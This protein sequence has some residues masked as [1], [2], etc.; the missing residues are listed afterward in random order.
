MRTPWLVTALYTI[1]GLCLSTDTIAA[2]SELH[3]LFPGYL[4]WDPVGPHASSTI[5]LASTY[6]AALLDYWNAASSENRA[7]CSFFPSNAEQ[8]SVAVKILNQLPTVRFALKG[9]GHNPNLGY[10]SVHQGV[11][12]AFRPNSQYAIPSEDGKTIEVGAGCKW[13]DVYS[14]LEPQGKT[15]VGG[16]LGDVGV[17]GLLLGGGLS[18]LSAQYGFACDNVISFEC[19]LANGTVVSA[20]STS[21]PDLFFALRGGGNQ[22]AIVTKMVLKTYDIGENGMVWGGVRTYT[23]DKRKQVIS[24]VTNFTATNTDPKAAIIPTFNAFSTLGL[25]LPGM[26]VF[27]FYDG[28][29]PRTNAFD[30]F[31]SIPSLSDDTRKRTYT[32]LTKEVSGGDMKGLRFQIRENTFPNMPAPEM[33]SFMNDHFDLLVKELTAAAVTDLLD[34]KL[35]SFAIQPMPRGIARASLDNGG[36]NALG[37]VPEH[38][39]RIWME[40]DIAWLN[41]FCDQKCPEFFEKLVQSQHT[42]HREKYSGIHPTNYQSGDLDF[43]SYNPIFMNDAMQGQDVLRSYGNETYARLSSIREAYDPQNFFSDRQAGF[44][45]T[46]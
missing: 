44:K 29:V 9:G 37:L 30:D 46:T 25:N 20:S 23:A 28:P 6:N 13:E 17:A 12:I 34:F 33:N 2:C 3:A 7:G 19:V 40:Y 42:L 1:T 43:L 26:L 35:F 32:D 45:F 5:S 41:P 24:A 10:S 4:V 18:Y 16:R 8:V 14:A 36:P 31:H 21:H 39:D 38:G 22:F 15:V 11:L 27:F